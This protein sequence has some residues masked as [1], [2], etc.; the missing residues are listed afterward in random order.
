[1]N[2][3]WTCRGLNLI[4]SLI[5]KNN[6][7]VLIDE[8]CLM[9]FHIEES[10]IFLRIYLQKSFNAA[11]SEKRESGL[12]RS[13]LQQLLPCAYFYFLSH[14][15]SPSHSYTHA[16][17]HA[18]T[19]THSCSHSLP[20][21]CSQALIFFSNTLALTHA[22]TH[23]HTHPRAQTQTHAHKHTHTHAH[24]HTHTDTRTQAHTHAHTHSHA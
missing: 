15:L 14:K 2:F 6:S 24:R 5:L 13:F 9:V 21:S 1:M 20:P 4:L 11:M 18:R 22:H 8:F 3:K 7:L 12:D 10:F 23:T 16:A 17:M 19:L